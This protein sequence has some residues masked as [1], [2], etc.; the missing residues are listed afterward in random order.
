MA[1]TASQ[2]KKDL[3]LPFFLDRR[4][5]AK[6]LPR[7]H[8]FACRA[9]FDIWKENIYIFSNLISEDGKPHIVYRNYLI[10]NIHLWFPV[11]QIGIFDRKNSIFFLEIGVFCKNIL[12]E[13]WLPRDEF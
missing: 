9:Y 7:A 12:Y 3:N 6:L 8:Q 10:F 11:F 4:E 5:L 13:Y 2:D 1:L